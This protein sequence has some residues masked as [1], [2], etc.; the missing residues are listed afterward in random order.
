MVDSI[1]EIYWWIDYGTRQAPK[2]F[3]SLGY[4]LGIDN[5]LVGA[6]GIFIVLQAQK[7]I[8]DFAKKLGI[9]VYFPVTAGVIAIM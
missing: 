6:S 7:V 1:N 9:T 5:N 8:D 4:C 2:L 3:D